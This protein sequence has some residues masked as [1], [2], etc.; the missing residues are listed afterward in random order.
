MRTLTWPPG[1]ATTVTRLPMQRLGTDHWRPAALTS[2]VG[3]TV[4][5]PASPTMD[6]GSVFSQV[7]L[8]EKSAPF[9]RVSARKF[10][11]FRRRHAPSFLT[12]R[13]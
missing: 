13:A 9:F 10:F 12:C 6:C 3:G 2:I 5:T 11:G 7:S 8:A 4:W 1:M